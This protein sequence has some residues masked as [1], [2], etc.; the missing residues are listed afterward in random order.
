MKKGKACDI[1]QLT[2]EHIQLCGDD[3][4]QCIINLIN[5]IIDNIYYLSRP[6]TKVGIAT[7]IYKGKTNQGLYLA[8]TAE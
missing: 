5:S 8:R 2:V 6:Q 7:C 1:H 4:Q 3:A